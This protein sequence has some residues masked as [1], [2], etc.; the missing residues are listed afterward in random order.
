MQSGNPFQDPLRFARQGSECAVVIFG[1]HGDLTRRMLVPALYRLF[2]DRRLSTGFAMV[3]ISRT[4]MSD[5]QFRE[6]L[7]DDAFDPA[8]WESFAR[9]I[10]YLPGDVNDPQ[11]YARLSAR[12]AELK[13]SATQA[14]TCSSISPRS[15]AQYWGR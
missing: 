8:Q 11:T 15:P 1:A 10:F 6:K 14:A 12:L 7:R 9:G 3:G 4:P 13:A 5:E 2:S